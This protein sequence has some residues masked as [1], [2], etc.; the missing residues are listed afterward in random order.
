MIQPFFPVI[1]GT[2][3]G[4]GEVKVGNR[5][6]RMGWPK[7]VLKKPSYNR[8]KTAWELKVS[9]VIYRATF[10]LLLSVILLFRGNY[11]NEKSE[12]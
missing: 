4:A 10:Y 11:L 7:K 12:V 2:K 6:N 5:S 1:S 8:R 9:G 3:N